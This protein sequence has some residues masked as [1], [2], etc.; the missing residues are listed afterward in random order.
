MKLISLQSGSNGN[1]IY[2]EADGVRLLF[3]AGISGSRAQQRLAGHG[4]D[5]GRVDGLIVS[6][7]HRDHACSMGIFHRKFGTPV[8]VTKRTFAAAGTAMRLGGLTDVREFT[9]GATL[10]FGS[11]RVETIRTPHDSVDGVAFVVDDGRSRLGILTDLGHV[12]VGLQDVVGSLDAVLVES[13][14][15][16]AMLACGPYPPF[17]KDRIAG[18][19]GHLSNREAAVLLKSVSR[20]QLQWACLGH[21]S[22]QNNTPELALDTHRRVLGKRLP[23]VVASRYHAGH[24]LEV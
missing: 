5:I 17:L 11:L 13:N 22:E 4:R 19:G 14:Y 12:F 6:H 9:A 21:L 15:D 20:R 8:Y 10:D 18:H 7:N 1:C 3:D 16:P 23:L 24:V 2:V